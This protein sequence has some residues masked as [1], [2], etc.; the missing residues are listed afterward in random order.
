MAFKYKDNSKEILKDIESGLIRGLLQ[1]S[2]YLATNIQ[3]ETPVVTGNLRQSIKP[4]GEIKKQ[5]G[6]KYETEVTTPVKYAS[7]VE[8]GGGKRKTKGGSTTVSFTP[9]AM[10]R[11]GAINSEGK[12]QDILLRNLK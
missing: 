2:E 6:G 3:K 12:I 11:K 4:T 10:F 9:R 1:G 8:Y 5:L 7:Y